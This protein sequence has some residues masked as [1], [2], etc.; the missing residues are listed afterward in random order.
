L[1]FF[2]HLKEHYEGSSNMGQT[3][4][5]SSKQNHQIDDHNSVPENLIIESFEDS[6]D[7]IKSEE[8]EA[9]AFEFEDDE[10]DVDEAFR[11]D[12]DK[13]V[14]T[15]DSSYLAYQVSDEIDN[16]SQND[17]NEHQVKILD[18]NFT[19]SNVI[20]N[21]DYIENNKMPPQS[22]VYNDGFCIEQEKNAGHI[23]NIEQRVECNNQVDEGDFN[24]DAN[25]EIEY[26][27]VASVDREAVEEDDEDD[28]DNTPLDQVR[29]MLIKTVKQP[30]K[31]K[32]HKDEAELN[33]CL[34]KISNF[35]CN[36]TDCNKT[37]NSRTALG[38]HLKTHSTERRF[39]CDQ[40]SLIFVL[41]QIQRS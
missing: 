39:V 17:S 22:Y 30:Q 36:F 9:D 29:L 15:I 6:Q 31:Q 19:N 8:I 32:L 38:Y 3:E 40:V 2:I 26:E 33:E 5:R 10:D 4:V 18:D 24:V 16:T 34:K 28:D 13:V 25:A 1:E 23:V 41:D 21:T 35:K 27:K 7:N 37:F 11:K 14:E 20:E 12:I